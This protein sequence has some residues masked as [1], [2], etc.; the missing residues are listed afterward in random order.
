MEYLIIVLV[1]FFF[2]VVGAICGLRSNLDSFH[3]LYW[4]I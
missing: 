3:R 4:W 2:S 1:C